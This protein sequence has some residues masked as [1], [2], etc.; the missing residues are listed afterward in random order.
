MCD[1][2]EVELSSELSKNEIILAELKLYSTLKG[3]L[4]EHSCPF[5]FYKINEHQ[6]PNMAKI[7]KMLFCITASSVPSECMFSKSG[8]LTSIKRTLLNLVLAENLL[9]LGL[10]KF[11][12]LCIFP[13]LKT[14][15][16]NLLTLTFT[17]HQIGI[18]LEILFKI[19]N[20]HKILR[21]K[22]E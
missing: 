1:D 17:P 4:N 15:F 16:E 22:V 6:L 18:F 11:D 10:N 7:A 5:L 13:C 3:S 8:E 9:I 20:Q 19:R 12:L 2:D 21:K 14:T